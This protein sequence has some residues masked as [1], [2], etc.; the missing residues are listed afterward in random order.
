MTLQPLPM[1]SEDFLINITFYFSATNILLKM[2][3]SPP[4]RSSDIFPFKKWWSLLFFPWLFLFSLLHTSFPLAIF[5]TKSPPFIYPSPSYAFL[6]PSIPFALLELSDFC[7]FFPS[8]FLW[9]F[10]H[11]TLSTFPPILI[12]VPLPLY[13]VVCRWL[14]RPNAK[15]SRWGLMPVEAEGAWMLPFLLGSSPEK[16]HLEHEIRKGSTECPY[17]EHELD[18]PSCR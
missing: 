5:P 12:F 6:L 9:R 16:W 11:S 13:R 7:H 4:L 17:S 8:P 3:L 14:L 1:D 2:F 15:P 18:H 10:F